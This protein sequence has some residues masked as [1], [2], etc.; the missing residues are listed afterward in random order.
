M[1]MGYGIE[2]V[3]NPRSTFQRADVECPVC[4]AG[5]RSPCIELGPIK[6]GRSKITRRSKLHPERAEAQKQ[7]RKDTRAAAR[8]G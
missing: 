5:K 8:R 3:H 1:S 2:Y 6:G 4:K 7:W